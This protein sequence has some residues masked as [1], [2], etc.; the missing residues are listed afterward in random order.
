MIL[1]IV[2]FGNPLLRKVAQ[3]VNGDAEINELIEDMFETMYFANGVGL[4]A[5]QVNKSLRLIVMDAS[6]YKEKFPELTD[7]KKVL[8]NPEILDE[9]GEI[10]SMSEGCLSIPH[11]DEYV[12][13]KSKIRIKYQ[14]ANKVWHDEQ[15]D[16]IMA[17]IMQHEYD[18]LNGVLFIDHLNPLRKMILKRKLTD[19]SK[20]IVDVDYKMIFHSS[21]KNGNK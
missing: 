10:F 21:K 12:E 15:Y 11:L 14:D 5:P 3:E 17:R 2:A 20:G 9:D 4:A 7:V 8:I 1:P 6:P 19:I 18:H 16:G 13:R